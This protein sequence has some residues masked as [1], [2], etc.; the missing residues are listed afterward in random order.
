MTKAKLLRIYLFLFASLWLLFGCVQNNRDKCDKIS[1]YDLNSIIDIIEKSDMI[2]FVGPIVVQ[3]QKKECYVYT[4]QKE[5]DFILFNTIEQVMRGYI[6][7]HPP[8]EKNT[9]HDR[10]D[11]LCSLKFC[12]LRL[13]K[14]MMD[15]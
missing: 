9:S 6:L 12:N 3:D 14:N 8:I 2:D 10:Y 4:I 7:G 11:V 15:H 5:R 1:I 13:R